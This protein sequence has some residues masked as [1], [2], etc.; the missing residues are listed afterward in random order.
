MANKE[1]LKKWRPRNVIRYFD[2]IQMKTGSHKLCIPYDQLSIMAREQQDIIADRGKIL[3]ARNIPL[4]T[5]SNA[6]PEKIKIKI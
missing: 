6:A 4:S 1:G 5:M 3:R 2:A